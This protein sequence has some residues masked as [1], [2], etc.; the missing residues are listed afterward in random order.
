[1]QANSFYVKPEKNNSQTFWKSQLN[2]TNMAVGLGSGNRVLSN[3][4]NTSI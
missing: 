1:L 2:T 3:L 4:T